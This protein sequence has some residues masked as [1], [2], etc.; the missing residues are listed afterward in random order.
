MGKIIA[1][2]PLDPSMSSRD[3]AAMMDGT[4]AADREAVRRMK[5]YGRWNVPAEL[6]RTLALYP[7]FRL[8]TPTRAA[9]ALA[10][11]RLLRR[12]RCTS[13]T[14]AAISVSA[15]RVWTDP[16]IMREIEIHR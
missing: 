13:F 15:G 12:E 4:A 11:G 14:A 5:V 7:E 1:L 9:S 2:E 8:S 10:A 16:D 3:I 6:L